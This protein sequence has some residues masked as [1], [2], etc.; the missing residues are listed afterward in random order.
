MESAPGRGQAQEVG[1]VL[2]F[3]G[4]PP[5]RS[6][7]TLGACQRCRL[8][9]PP[10]E[11]EGSCILSDRPTRRSVCAGKLATPWLHGRLGLALF[12]VSSHLLPPLPSFPPA[13]QRGVTG[14]HFSGHR[15]ILYSKSLTGEVFG[16][17]FN[18]SKRNMLMICE[19]CSTTC[20][21]VH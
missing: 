11:R 21:D 3:R 19:G 16:R 6:L 17:P 14:S 2:L 5:A 13:F 7:P 20:Y 1:S 9:A 8:E 18:Q 12:S 10:A 15:V 4:G